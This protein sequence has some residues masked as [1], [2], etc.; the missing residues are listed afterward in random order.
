VAVVKTMVDLGADKEAPTADG[1]RPLH[2]AA[3]EGHV[4][5]VG[6]LA[7]LGADVNSQDDDGDSLLHMAAAEGYVS[8]VKTLAE[9]GANKE[10]SMLIYGGRPLHIAAYKGHAAV[11]HWRSWGRTLAL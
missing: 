6:T 10:A 4:E 1:F 3:Q 7:E 11:V 5:T 8:V 2:C 9:A